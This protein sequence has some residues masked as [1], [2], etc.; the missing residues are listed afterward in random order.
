M[1][2]RIAFGFIIVAGVAVMIRTIGAGWD[3]SLASAPARASRLFKDSRQS[4]A[5]ARAQ[6]R[7][8]VT[9][10]VAATPGGVPAVAE[11]AGRLGGEVRYREDEIGYLRV[12]IPIDQASEFVEF[13]RIESAAMDRD[14]SYPARLTGDGAPGVENTLA[15]APNRNMLTPQDPPRRAT[16]KVEN[17]ESEPWPPAW[18]DYPLRH[19]YSPLGDIDAAEWR[20]QHPTYD[21]RG[22]TIAVLDGNF[23]LLLPEFQTAYDANGKKVPK[24]ADFLNVTDP[25]DDSSL[26]PQWV[27][28]AEQV[29][30]RGGSVTFQ[31][32]TF[33]APRDGEFRI[34]FF[35]E[36]R[37]NEPAN[38]AYINQDVDQNGNPKGDDGLFGVLW[39]EKTNDIWVDTNRDLSFADEKAMTDY[40]KRQDVGVFGKDN[41]ETPVRESIGFAV[42]TDPVNK[43]VS[44][45]IGAYQHSTII[46]GSVA[47]NRE[48]KGRVQGIAPGARIVS[49]FWGI[50]VAHSMVEGLIAAFKHPQVDVIVLEQHVGVASITYFLA[51]ARHPISVI[52]QRLIQKYQKLMFVPGSNQ[53]GSAIVAEDGL[54]PAAVSVG[55]YQGRESYRINAGF[56]PETADNLHWGAL[57]HGPSGIGALKPDLLAPSGQMSTDPGYRKGAVIRGLFRLP[58][59]YS[60]DGGT[61]TATPMAAGCAALVISAAKQ[62]GVSFDALRLKAALTGSARHIPNL[63]AHEQGAGLIQVEAAFELLRKLQ[64]VSIPTITS[65]APV[66]TRLGGLLQTPYQ[67]VGIYEREGWA[68]GARGERIIS[69]TRVSGPA[70]PMTF[71]LSWQGNDGTFASAGALTLPLNTPVDLPVTIAVKEAGL[72]SAILTL[73]HPSIPGHVYR[74]L[75]TVVAPLEFTAENKFTVTT[76]I[77][78]PRPGD[79]GVFVQ[80]P[81]GA[82]AM[83]F[84]ATSE[85]Q[86]AIRLRMISSGREE[87]WGRE[88]PGLSVTNPEP[89]VWELNACINDM[90]RE[91]D[92]DRPRPLKP[93]RVKV[94]ATLAAV[95]VGG[96]LSAQAVAGG[97][98]SDTTIELTNRFGAVIASVTSA[99]L[100]SAF[101]TRREIAQGEQHLYEV[102]V[103]QGAAS[104]RARLSEVAE[105]RADLDLYLFDCSALGKKPEASPAPER[106]KGNKAPPAPPAPCA[107]RGKAATV[108]RDGEVEITMPAP[109]RWVIV[110]DAYS[111]PS[112]RTAYTY[113]DVFT[114][115]R[116]GAVVA[117]DSPARRDTGG[118]WISPAHIWVASQS[119][120]SQPEGS[121]TGNGRSLL[122]RIVVTN[123]D[124]R[125][126]GAELIAPTGSTATLGSIDLPLGT[127][128]TK[129]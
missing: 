37:F 44:I 33:R 34:G 78:I 112:G 87:I 14:D 22:V 75:N 10:L 50:G 11:Y 101:Q 100:G 92:P 97:S 13:D 23:D 53:P 40:I 18:G 27:N 69:F 71:S 19:P 16:A 86:A 5:I 59:G 121:L 80:V 120:E 103:P 51:D 28:M 57:A 64:T 123:P 106:E 35:N 118:A 109:G 43:Y 116:L 119:K 7:K 8:V 72:H 29:S 111:I 99:S 83:N 67:G 117:A 94:T 76:E 25:R 9:L 115:P 65:R 42:Q 32:K 17:Q 12:N 15:P 30:A 56:V 114:H 84:T 63:L 55:G 85:D 73:D 66:R 49:M 2:R 98:L 90:A 26:I 88:G 81:P 107:P 104:L 74:L 91:F 6:G 31:G 96:D 108:E 3:Q 52:A 95:T 105:A 82:A 122:A 4:L 46:L 129:K 38:L 48:P 62:N 79:R 36:R 113:L 1:W 24:V 126:T 39:D 124:W 21:G 58:P 61:S 60:V 20:K 77:V 89:G 54:A 68:I 93:A 47:G 128:L 102:N 70:Q 41:P 45:N 110:V 127:S 125:V